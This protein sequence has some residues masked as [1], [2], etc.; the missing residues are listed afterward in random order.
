[1]RIHVRWTSKSFWAK[2]TCVQVCAACMSGHVFL[3]LQKCIPLVK[4]FSK[5][6]YKITYIPTF[7]TLLTLNTF[8]QTEQQCLGAV[9]IYRTCLNRSFLHVKIFWQTEHSSLFNKCLRLCFTRCKKNLPHTW[10][11]VFSVTG[12]DELLWTLL[13][14]AEYCCFELNGLAHISQIKDI[15]F[16][17]IRS[18]W[19]F[20]EE[21]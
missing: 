7:S 3:E 5:Y 11:W 2:S 1:M 4:A 12:A 8:P 15:D 19:R 20:S 9:C 16:K 14:C 10:H 17:W 13:K 18:A 21:A 6:V